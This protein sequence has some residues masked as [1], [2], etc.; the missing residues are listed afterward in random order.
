MEVGEVCAF[1]KVRN[2]PAYL[3]GTDEEIRRYDDIVRVLLDG[4]IYDL[5]PDG[6]MIYTDMENRKLVKREARW[7]V[8][9][10]ILYINE[11]NRPF[12]REAKIILLTP[13]SLV[14]VPIIDGEAAD[15]QM[16]FRKA[17]RP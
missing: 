14:M 9:D 1:D 11:L 8:K 2:S 17:E 6:L 10:G 13:S 3:F 5:R 12:K 15:S 16:T 4:T 7:A